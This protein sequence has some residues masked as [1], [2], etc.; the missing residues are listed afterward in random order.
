[1]LKEK[2]RELNDNGKVSVWGAGAKGATFVN[3][4]DNNNGLI[5]SVIDINKINKDILYREQLMK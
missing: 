2:L 3:L 1:M 5:D 4:I